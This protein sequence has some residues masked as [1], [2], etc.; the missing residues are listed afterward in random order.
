VFIK[1]MKARKA[2][3]EGKSGVHKGD[4]NQKSSSRRKKWCS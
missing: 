4:E 1:E 3:E 2:A